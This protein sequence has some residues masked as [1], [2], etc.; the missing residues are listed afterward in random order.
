[1]LRT[2]GVLRPSC[3]CSMLTLHPELHKWAYD[4]SHDLRVRTQNHHRKG[5][6]QVS[7]SCTLLLHRIIV[8]QHGH[9]TMCGSVH[10]GW[11]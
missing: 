6:E 4:L 8:R 5:S 9:A 2:C 11:G 1:V 10:V 7:G 3:R